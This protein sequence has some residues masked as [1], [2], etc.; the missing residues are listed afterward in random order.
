MDR[1][2]KFNYHKKQLKESISKVNPIIEE[3]QIQKNNI[4][5]IVLKK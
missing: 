4:S 2:G 3:S 5:N 1:K